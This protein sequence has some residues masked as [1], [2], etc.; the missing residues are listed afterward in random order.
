MPWYADGLRFECQPD[1]GACCVNHGD[2]AYVY[3]DPADVRRL[4]RSLRLPRREFLERFT[5]KDGDALALRMDQPACPFLDGVRCTVYRA[6]PT[7]CRTF[8]FWSENLTS[9]RRWRALSRFCPGIDRG[10]K[11]HPL[12]VIQTHLAARP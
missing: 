7:Q 3:L 8:P 4:T 12:H 1:C 2:Y 9:R 6:R 10:P 11:T 5:T